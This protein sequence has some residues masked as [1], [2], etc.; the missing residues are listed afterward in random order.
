MWQ[1][2]TP[3]ALI[4]F[5]R[6]Q[7]TE[8]VFKAIRQAK[9]P[10]LLAIADGPRAACPGEAEKCAAAR[11]I[12]NRV[13]WDCEVLTNFSDINLG[14]KKRVDSGLT[15]V[16]DMV[17]SAIVLE[18]DCLPH[19][20]FFRFCEELLERYRNNP[21]IMM[22]SGNNFQFGRSSTEDS[23][24]FSRYN[25]IWGWAT[26]RRAW[27]LYDPTM[28]RWPELRESN[29][30]EDILQESDAIKYWANIFK[31]NY[32]TLE[33]WDYAWVFTSWLYN[34]LTIL[35]DV[36]LVCNIGFGAEA[37]HTK[38]ASIFANIPT[39]A[40]AF[41]LHHP[42]S[43]QRHELADDF[44]EKVVFSGNLGMVLSAIRTRRQQ[45]SST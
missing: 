29:W 33:N 39:E 43:I 36:N 13:D 18:D 28:S 42:A 7:T 3:V 10:K 45:P 44:T 31:V 41:P 21:E 14:L 26:W 11:A 23:Y 16:F 38:T 5:N 35:P 22:I 4:I 15:W 20:T 19:P 32:E 27:Q 2:E 34:G 37:T 30:L 24:Y 1:L 17:E 12:L 8:R 25:L 9:P 40:M 6:P